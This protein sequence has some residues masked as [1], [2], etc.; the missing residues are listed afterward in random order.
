MHQVRCIFGKG[1]IESIAT[2][3]AGLQPTGCSS[4]FLSIIYSVGDWL[5][6][7]IINYSI[8]IKPT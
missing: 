2:L 8:I 5:L 3:E 6:K 1:F 7:I 4:V